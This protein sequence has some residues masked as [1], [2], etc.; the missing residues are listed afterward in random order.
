MIRDVS[1]VIHKVRVG[2]V[3]SLPIRDVCLGLYIILSLNYQVRLVDIS[4][5]P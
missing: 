3:H 4:S 5:G 1:R 2:H